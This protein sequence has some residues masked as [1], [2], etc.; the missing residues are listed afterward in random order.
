MN[1]EMMDYGAYLNESPKALREL[2]NSYP[3]INC[4]HAAPA[5]CDDGDSLG[6]HASSLRRIP[7]TAG[8]AGK[9]SRGVTASAAATIAAMG[10]AVAFAVTFALGVALNPIPVLAIVLML[11]TPRGLVRGAALSAGA[12]AGLA[13]VTAVVYLVESG[14]DPGRGRRDGHL[15]LGGAAPLASCWC[16]SRS[17]SGARGPR[18]GGDAPEMPG[19]VSA[20]ET[21]RR[22]G[23]RRRASR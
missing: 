9:L 16:G 11:A 2:V 14:A 19:W 6:C 4:A 18:A 5:R 23:R 12:L 22:R 8:G 20:L 13:A 21:S 1:P 10:E 3:G 15:G 17:A 7:A